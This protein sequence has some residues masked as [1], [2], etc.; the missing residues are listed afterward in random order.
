VAY[1]GFSFIDGFSKGME[2]VVF[3]ANE[4][5]GAGTIQD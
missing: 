2:T 5:F 3:V 4:F 1:G